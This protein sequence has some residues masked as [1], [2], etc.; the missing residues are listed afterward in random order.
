MIWEKRDR[1]REGLTLQD[2]RRLHVFYLAKKV[3]KTIGFC[4]QNNP[5]TASRL[6]PP[7]LLSHL[8]RFT[9][10]GEMIDRIQS[11]RQ[12]GTKTWDLPEGKYAIIAIIIYVG[13]TNRWKPKADD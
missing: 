5:K 4:P 3:S 12:A 10:H 7:K 2:F 13:S 11:Y 8:R 6:I 9:V 1:D